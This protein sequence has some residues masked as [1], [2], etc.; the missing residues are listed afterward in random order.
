MKENKN[1]PLWQKIL[2]V[3]LSL[4]ILFAVF[5]AGWLVR[6][7]AVSDNISSYKWARDLI[8][9]YYYGDIDEEALSNVSLKAL[10]SM[11]DPYSEYYTAE[12]YEALIRENSGEHSGVGIMYNFIDG[13]GAVLISV[14][15]NSPAYRAGLR[16]GD[17]LT[18]AKLENGDRVEFTTSAIMSSFIDKCAKDEKFTLYTE[19]GGEFVLAKE[20]YSS[21]YVYMC[22]NS[23]AWTTVSSEDGNVSLI[24]SYS[25]KLEFLP[26]NAAYINLYQFYGNAG[27]EFGKL[28]GKFNEYG[29]TSLILDLRNNG[30]GYVSVMQDLAGYFVDSS[31]DMNVAMTAKYKNGNM[32]SY[33]C[34]SHTENLVPDGTEIYVLC[35]SGTASASEALIG[36]L[37][38]YGLLDYQNIFISDFSEEYLS[39]AGTGLK[40]AQ[41][42]GKGIM[43]TTYVNYLTGEALKLTNAQIY[44]P[45][46]K[47]I[48]GVGLTAKD[49]C[50]LVPAAWSATKNDEELQSVISIIESRV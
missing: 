13:K 23:T 3:V 4:V 46:G 7:C 6:S 26:E 38:S 45:N 20:V 27:N 29:C 22:T 8:D 30:G 18:G 5:A 1:F 31:S 12:E 39:W 16:K 15:G 50:T 21:S 41:T 2:S 44:W 36:V 24:E 48:H 11:L 35:N 19:D 37:V 49:G 34:Y 40:T 17:C 32:D 42:Y 14:V 25:D 33:Y 47:C 9:N 10:T 43:Q 28:M